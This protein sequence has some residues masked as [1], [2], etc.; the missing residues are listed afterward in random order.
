MIP[1]WNEDAAQL[2]SAVTD[3][4]RQ[5]RPHDEL[6][7]VDAD[8]TPS[9]TASPELPQLSVVSAPPGRGGQMN[10][11]AAQADGDWLLFLHADSR[12]ASGSLDAIRALQPSA[13]SEWGWL[14]ARLDAP[15]LGYRVIERAIGLRSKLTGSATGDQAIFVRRSVFDT[16]GKFPAWPLFEDLDLVDRLRRRSRG[17]PLGAQVVTSARRYQAHGKAK[18]ALRMW[19]LRA[20][21]RCGASPARL[22]RYYAPV[23]SGGART[24]RPPAR[25]PAG[26]PPRPRRSAEA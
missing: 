4:H 10:L 13:A 24:G 15:G 1:A 12:L 3:A 22:A 8:P 19:A 20:A 5:L 9:L 7:L 26:S 6:I 25:A 2:L 11:G 21:F 17:R 16:V 18:T 23:T 14:T